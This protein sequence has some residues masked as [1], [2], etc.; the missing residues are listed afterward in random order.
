VF[1]KNRIPEY[2]VL[3]RESRDSLLLF[4]LLQAL[5]F[6]AMYSDRSLDIVCANRREF[7]VWTTALQVG[8]VMLYLVIIHIFLQALLNGFND[9]EAIEAAGLMKSSRNATSSLV[10]IK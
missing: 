9:R 10:V 1:K 4:N 2:E 5:S 3:A 8:V 6:S 7:E